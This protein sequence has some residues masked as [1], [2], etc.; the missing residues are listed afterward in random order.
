MKKN[1]LD[2]DFNVNHLSY[3]GDNHL[4]KDEFCKLIDL[5]S[6]VHKKLSEM[7]LTFSIN[8]HAMKNLMV[9]IVGHQ[10]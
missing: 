3:P 1:Q 9:L 4:Q 5:P 6:V 2:T 10:N 7:D 8:M